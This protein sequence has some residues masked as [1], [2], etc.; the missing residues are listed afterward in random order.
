MDKTVEGK[1]RQQGTDVLPGKG[2]GE[3][4]RKSP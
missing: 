2:S 4:K 1:N 3:K